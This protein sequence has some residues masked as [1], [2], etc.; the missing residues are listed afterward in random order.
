[1]KSFILK[2]RS[3]FP[4]VCSEQNMLRLQVCIMWPTKWAHLFFAHKQS[5][6]RM[7]NF[8]NAPLFS[9]LFFAMRCV[10]R[11]TILTFQGV[12]M[13]SYKG[14]RHEFVASKWIPKYFQTLNLRSHIFQRVLYRHMTGWAG[15]PTNLGQGL[16]KS[17]IWCSSNGD[18]ACSLGSRIDRNLIGICLNWSKHSDDP[19]ATAF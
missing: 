18:L 4:F 1:M 19:Q 7:T 13:L 12:F 16:R 15:S 8:A 9:C 14:I 6:M 5:L 17:N 2:F 11:Q 3:D 10:K